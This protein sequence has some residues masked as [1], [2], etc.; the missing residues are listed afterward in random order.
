MVIE[1][2]LV[3]GNYPLIRHIHTE[4]AAVEL[5]FKQKVFEPRD[6]AKGQV[7]R[8]YF[9]M[10]DRYNL[11]M[12][13]QQQQLLMKAWDNKYPPTLGKSSVIIESLR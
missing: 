4:C 5:I 6:E 1:A 9:Y 13:R 10:H 7:A 8:V 3:L 2:I 11:S 12:S